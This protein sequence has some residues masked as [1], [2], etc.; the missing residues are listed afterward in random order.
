MYHFMEV[1]SGTT[2]PIKKGRKI[3]RE[4][5]KGTRKGGEEEFKLKSYFIYD[6]IT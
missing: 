4:R 5:G 3:E 6:Y 2:W 1:L